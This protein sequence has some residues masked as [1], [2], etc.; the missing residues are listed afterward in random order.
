MLSTTTNGKIWISQIIISLKQ[1]QKKTILSNLLN[2]PRVV[3]NYNQPRIFLKINTISI[4]SIKYHI[5]NLENIYNIN[6][7]FLY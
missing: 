6:I 1:K 5:R 3:K 2:L 4:I 7:N